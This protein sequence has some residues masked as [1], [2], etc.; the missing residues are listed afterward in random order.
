MSL[1]VMHSITRS[2]EHPVV[3]YVRKYEIVYLNLDSHVAY[4]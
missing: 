3:E 1:I 2:C 4:W